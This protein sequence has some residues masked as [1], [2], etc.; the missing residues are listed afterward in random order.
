MKRRAKISNSKFQ[1]T[2]AL[3]SDVPRG[4]DMTPLHTV[5]NPHTDVSAS[6]MKELVIDSSEGKKPKLASIES[7]LKC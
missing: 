5:E 4:M 7:R 1:D 3:T 6:K 2:L